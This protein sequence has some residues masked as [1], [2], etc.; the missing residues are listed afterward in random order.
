MKI[1]SPEEIT[2]FVQKLK[3]VSKETTWFANIYADAKISSRNKLLKQAADIIESLQK[4]IKTIDDQALECANLLENHFKIQ[5]EI[6][7]F[8]QQQDD[9]GEE[10]K[11]E[12]L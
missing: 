2:Q 8:K 1:Y 5:E 11:N 10:I 12:T 7:R 3:K 9:Y 6:E 4:T